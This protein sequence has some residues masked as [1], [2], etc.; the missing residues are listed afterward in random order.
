MHKTKETDS[1][2]ATTIQ[3]RTHQRKQLAWC[4]VFGESVL[5]SSIENGFRRCKQIKARKDASASAKAAHMVHCIWR[6]CPA[7]FDREWLLQM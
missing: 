4:T 5:Q 1:D 2:Q 7:V 6:K 3:E